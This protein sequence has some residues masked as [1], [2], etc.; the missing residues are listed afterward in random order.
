MR[1]KGSWLTNSWDKIFGSI[2][3]KNETH[4]LH[5]MTTTTTRNWLFVEIVYLLRQSSYRLSRYIYRFFTVLKWTKRHKWEEYNRKT[6]SVRFVNFFRTRTHVK[7][8]NVIEKP[9]TKN[10]NRTCNVDDS[11]NNSIKMWHLA[12]VCV[13]VCVLLCPNTGRKKE[14]KSGQNKISNN[15]QTVKEWEGGRH[16]K[17]IWIKRRRRTHTQKMHTIAKQLK[18]DSEAC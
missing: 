9:K 2:L 12:N 6:N 18:Q 10:Q 11:K 1:E 17:A 7:N 8:A 16:K 15:K 3:I 14:E 4:Q 5:R 13:W